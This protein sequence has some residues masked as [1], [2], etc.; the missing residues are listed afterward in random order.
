[1]RPVVFHMISSPPDTA[2]ELVAGGIVVATEE[3]ICGMTNDDPAPVLPVDAAADA[4]GAI[5]RDTERG[6]CCCGCSAKT[7]PLGNVGVGETWEKEVAEDGVGGKDSNL[8]CGAHGVAAAASDAG[9]ASAAVVMGV[10]AP[11]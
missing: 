5:G 6:A 2:A 4:G 1:M 11:A 7:T 9:L 10:V 3:G 8:G